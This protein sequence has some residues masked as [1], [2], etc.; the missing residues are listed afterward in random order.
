LPYRLL[1]VS[2]SRLP[3]AEADDIVASII[4]VARRRNSREGITGALL[5]TGS[6]FAQVLEGK[7]EAITALMADIRRDRGHHEI[8]IVQQGR[9]S[10]P[11]FA[12]WSMAYC[13]RSTYVRQLVEAV[14]ADPD[15]PRH[16]RAA[17][18]A[19]LMFMQQSALHSEE[20]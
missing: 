4:D 7:A 16:R 11:Q 8:E 10:S 18:N 1:Y 5:F 19:L 20:A 14:R 9:V 6:S 13:G 3:Q 12:R 17:R 2:T 15:D